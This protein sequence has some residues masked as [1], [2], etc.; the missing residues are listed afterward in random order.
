[1]HGYFNYHSTDDEKR[2]LRIHVHTLQRSLAVQKQK[3][4]N[5][6]K[7]IQTWKRK[8]EELEKINGKLKKE[9]EEIKRQ[10]DLYKNM[11]FKKNVSSEEDT[12]L[13]CME[14]YQHQEP[15]EDKLAT[16]D[17]GENYQ[18]RL[19]SPKE[20]IPQHVLIVIVN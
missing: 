13:C 5:A 8:Y 20:Y 18:S 1:M 17:M 6:E 12:T 15:G 11:L 7:E 3:R 10:R 16:L 2:K 19:I 14:R 9:N 4:D